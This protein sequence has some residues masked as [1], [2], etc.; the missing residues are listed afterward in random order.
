MWQL[1]HRSQSWRLR[2]QVCS[3]LP[4][5]HLWDFARLTFVNT[6]MSKRKLQWFVDKG[7]VDGWNDP[8]F[9]T[10]QACGPETDAGLCGFQQCSKRFFAFLTL[11]S[12]LRPRVWHC[13]AWP[14][15]VVPKQAIC[16]ELFVTRT[17]L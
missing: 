4:H 10:V 8:R 15:R 16:A 11:A 14:Y 1:L 3:E 2:L 6:V 17:E 7:I 5:V 12:V 13:A 9:P